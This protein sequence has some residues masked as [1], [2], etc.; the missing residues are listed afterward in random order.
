M[1]TSTRP[2]RMDRAQITMKAQG[3]REHGHCGE[4]TTTVDQHIRH[5]RARTW[6]GGKCGNAAAATMRLFNSAAL[7]PSQ[8][9][10]KHPA[11]HRPELGVDAAPGQGLLAGG[12]GPLMRVFASWPRSGRPSRRS[13]T[14]AAELPGKACAAVRL[15]AQARLPG[16]L[17]ARCRIA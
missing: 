8:E 11:G 6:R 15:F 5:C 14:R 4:A 9:R 3:R 16:R 13:S 2:R 10:C 7:K 12:R 17:L 1:P